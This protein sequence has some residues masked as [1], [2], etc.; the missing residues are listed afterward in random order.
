MLKLNTNHKLL[1]MECVSYSYHKDVKFMN[2]VN[3][4][5]ACYNSFPFPENSAFLLFGTKIL[6]FKHRQ[7]LAFKLKFTVKINTKFTVKT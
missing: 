2:L 3:V 7:I 4:S 1:Q 5:V 6:I